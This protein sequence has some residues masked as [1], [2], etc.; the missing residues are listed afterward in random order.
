MAY[1]LAIANIISVC[2]ELRLKKEITYMYMHVNSFIARKI[3]VEIM[4]LLTR[5]IF[6][7]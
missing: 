1:N 2:S 4:V 5:Y 7:I 6:I 3:V